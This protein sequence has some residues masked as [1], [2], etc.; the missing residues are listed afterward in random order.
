MNGGKLRS[1]MA[2]S[3]N[4]PAHADEAWKDILH[5]YFQ[6]FMQF[7]FPA[8][9]DKID[10]QAG[11]EVLDKELQAITTDAIIGKR[12]VDMLFKVRSI[13][14][15]DCVVLLH[16]DIQGAYEA[17]FAERMYIYNY[18]VFNLRKL[19]VMTLV[20]LADN[21]PNWRPTQ[22]QSEIWG[23]TITTFNFE[24]VKLLDW[25]GR[26]AELLAD[27]NPFGIV[28]A[29]HLAAQKT[30]KNPEAR[31][32]NKAILTRQLYERGF[33]QDE[34]I[35]LYRFMDLIMTLPENLKIRYNEVI[36]EIEKEKNVQ[37]LTSI[38]ERGWQKGIQ[39][40]MQASQ[41]EVW[42]TAERK[43]KLEAARKM[44]DA[45]SPIE[46]VKRITDLEDED[47]VEPK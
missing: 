6:A 14:G 42:Q 21:R 4:P 11:F 29:V 9:A 32:D 36:D 30:Q 28:V 20:V 39:Q 44:L 23:R 1:I 3:T 5:G 33:G 13:E 27:A 37:I 25:E 24:M 19:P 31:F 41:A 34:I 38:E 47:L 8:L 22:Y 46:F 12:L 26:E 10:W 43:A 35:N 45:G 18:L 40:G 2:A 7:F 17:N 15:Q 16:L